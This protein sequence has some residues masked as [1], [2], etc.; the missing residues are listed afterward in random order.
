MEPIDQIHARWVAKHCRIEGDSIMLDVRGSQHKFPLRQ[1]DSYEKIVWWLLQL[2]K[3]PDMTLAHIE[4]FVF[5]T[6]QY[7]GLA[8]E[9]GS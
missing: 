5:I 8:P 3:I 9:V 6:C 7:H 4:A 1:C 2:P